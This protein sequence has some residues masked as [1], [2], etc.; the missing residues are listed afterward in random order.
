M[1]FDRSVNAGFSAAPSSLLYIKQDESAR[2]INAETES[3]DEASVLNNV[4]RLI[5]FRRS[6]EALLN[7]GDFELVW[8][9]KNEYP[10]AYIRSSASERLLVLL[11]PADRD[12]KL[13]EK[14]AE[15]I[16]NKEELFRIGGRNENSDTAGK[17]SGVVY[18]L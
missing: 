14:L 18:R 15:L 9:E 11:N 6:H 17:A 3:E 13:S 4:K 8:C 16:Q 10:V 7:R 1:A 2:Y 12:V 5:A